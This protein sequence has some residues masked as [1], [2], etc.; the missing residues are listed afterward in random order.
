MK[1]KTAL[2]KKKVRNHLDEDIKESKKSIDEDKK[3][4]TAI[5]R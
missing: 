5:K 4:K 3:L 2:I 1:I